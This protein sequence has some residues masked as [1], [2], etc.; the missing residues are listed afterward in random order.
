MGHD[1]NKPIYKN[2]LNNSATMVSAAEPWGPTV[3]CSHCDKKSPARIGYCLY[4]AKKLTSQKKPKQN[5]IFTACL[6]FVALG[7]ATAFWFLRDNEEAVSPG[8]GLL[9]Q[10]E[11][12]TAE[13]PQEPLPVP[14]PPE[15]ES[16][17]T[18]TTTH[19]TVPPQT[20]DAFD[21]LEAEQPQPPAA[22]RLTL[23]DTF[24]FR[25]NFE[26]TYGP[27]IE[28]LPI[29]DGRQYR[30]RA[31]V[32]VYAMIR[33]PVSVTSTAD[34]S[35]TEGFNTA[36]SLSGVW[37]PESN[38]EGRLSIADSGMTTPIGLTHGRS[39]FGDSFAPIEGS[40][41]PGETQVG[42]IYI[43]FVGNGYYRIGH[44]NAGLAPDAHLT[45][46]IYIQ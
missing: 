28:I 22:E 44:A 41:A 4:C 25:Q 23:G 14:E 45:V 40:V 30:V 12:E 26:V 36:F 33:V 10:Q 13:P 35:A 8:Q 32:Y 20:E 7:A 1:F 29:P 46:Y 27:E 15:T 38:P 2:E 16:A 19:E 17:A 3:T 37:G 21:E 34:P 5:L 6:I 43:P 11:Q 39:F 42:H 18:D 9:T 31:D 24:T